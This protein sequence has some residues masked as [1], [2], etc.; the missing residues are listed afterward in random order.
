MLKSIQRSIFIIL[1]AC[2]LQA[3]TTPGAA[4]QQILETVAPDQLAYVVGKYTV[5]CE[6][7]DDATDCRPPFNRI[8]IYFKGGP[9]EVFRDDISVETSTL[10]AENPDFDI[11]DAKANTG[12]V[13]FCRPVP[14]GDYSIY[15]MTYWNFAGGGSGFYLNDNKSFH[16]P[17]RAKP[18]TLSVLD[19]LTVTSGQRKT[20]LGRSVG[21]PGG[22]EFSSLNDAEIQR[23]VDKCPADATR[24]ARDGQ[25]LG[26]TQSIYPFES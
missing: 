3:C 5:S 24:K 6:P 23:A 21:T 26:N 7:N 11:I 10:G 19:H 8:A 17:F 18:G 1:G 20:L 9:P 2:A 15:S 4:R 25:G 13:Y 16:V 12:S 22:I 14:P